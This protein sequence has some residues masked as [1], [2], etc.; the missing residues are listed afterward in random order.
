MDDAL[1]GWQRENPGR[2]QLPRVFPIV[3]Y[4]GQEKWTV[5]P[6]LYGT[7]Q[8]QRVSFSHDLVNLSTIPDSELSA[9]P[10]LRARFMVMKYSKAH[11]LE[12]RLDS[13]F[14]AASRSLSPQASRVSASADTT[15]S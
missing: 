4:H 9:D 8:P 12:A 15:R 10:D 6:D 13:L 14:T 11:D 3:V 2:T 1:S 7:A 5:P